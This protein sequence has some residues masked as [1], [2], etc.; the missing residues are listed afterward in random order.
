MGPAI[1]LVLAVLVLVSPRALL[2]ARGP[3]PEVH[4]L[5]RLLWWLNAL[6]CAFLHRL[7]SNA[8]APLPEH[9]PAI[10]IANHTCGIDHMVLQ[11]GCG[12][13]LGF[14]IARE[15]YEFWAC[16]PFCKLLRCIPVKRDGHDLAAIRAALR[17][18]EEGRVVPI[19]PEGRILPT[20][21]REL[22]EGKPGAAFIALHA[23]V[24]VI[25]AYI[26]GTP[27]TN[28]VW[29]ALVT[30]SQARVLFGPPIDL[31]E[32]ARG[33]PN[34]K[35]VLAET[36]RRL[37]GAIDA[38]RARG[39]EPE[40]GERGR[41]DGSAGSHGDARRPERPAEALSEK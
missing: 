20:S 19:F 8:P 40:D 24:P 26:R 32:V 39:L 1:L 28:N 6:Y 9:G 34:D 31:S 17:A 16:R 23:R 30:P 5:L 10:L 18:L 3:R 27:E 36:T 33:R 35:A 41:V 2:P 14:L 22:G 37:M 13:V 12:R 21:G 25:P 38:L 15:F 4:G 29:K 7:E 11:A